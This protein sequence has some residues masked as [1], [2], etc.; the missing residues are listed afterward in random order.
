MLHPIKN[1]YIMETRSQ[2]SR[3]VK[4]FTTFKSHLT[5]FIVVNVVLWA[6]WLLGSR[7]DLNS[8][9]IYISLIWFAIL[10]IHYIVAY[11]I[12]NVKKNN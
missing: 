4:L 8:F 12:F 3:L 1:E 10:A 5:I 9:L 11:E 6:I 2:L 7:R